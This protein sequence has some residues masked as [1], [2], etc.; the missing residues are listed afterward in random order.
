MTE[1][2]KLGDIAMSARE[3]AARLEGELAGRWAGCKKG[4]N[5][6]VPRSASLACTPKGK[7]TRR[8][9]SDSGRLQFNYGHDQ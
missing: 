7:I 5:D 6:C 4:V 1:T 2:L 9:R 3:K 8:N